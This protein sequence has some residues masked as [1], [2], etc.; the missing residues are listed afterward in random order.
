MCARNL[1]VVLSTLFTL[2]A[3]GQVEDLERV[4][5]NEPAGV[6]SSSLLEAHVGLNST[7]P[8]PITLISICSLSQ[9]SCS[10][11]LPSFSRPVAG[12]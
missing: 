1:I 3:C 8:R 10:C 12:V 7:Q 2:T 9:S 4:V 11:E 6:M 5:D